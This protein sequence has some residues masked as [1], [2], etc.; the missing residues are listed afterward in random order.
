MNPVAKTKSQG[1]KAFID[2]M[3]SELL[4]DGG[5]GDGDGDSDDGV[6]GCSHFAHADEDNR[7]QGQL[8]EDSALMTVPDEFLTDA[9]DADDDDD[10]DEEGAG[11]ELQKHKE[12]LEEEAR[13][14]ANVRKKPETHA[15]AAGEGETHADAVGGGG[16]HAEDVHRVEHPTPL[17]GAG[18]TPKEP[19]AELLMARHGDPYRT[20]LDVRWQLEV[21][22][23][24]HR[25]KS[26][27]GKRN[28]MY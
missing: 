22:G 12:E 19:L 25:S 20:G 17:T 8:R 15:D 26:V 4:H 21:S 1:T 3:D 24:W 9:E 13:W 23:R 28:K 27:P 14:E 7:K 6:N 18:R 10:D 5:D 2:I 16:M 11:S